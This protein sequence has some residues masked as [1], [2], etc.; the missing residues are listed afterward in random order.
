MEKRECCCTVAGNVNWHSHYGRWYRFLKKL[1]IKP[2]YDSEI[3]LL[4][5][6]SEETK[7]EKDTCTQMFTEALFTIERTWKKPRCPLTD[8]CIKSWVHTHNGILLGHK[9]ECLWVGSDEV[10]EPRTYYTEWS[11]SERER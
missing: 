7:V 1:G 4:G 3:P 5:I 9:N 8:E 10:N 2:P 6:Y 11:K